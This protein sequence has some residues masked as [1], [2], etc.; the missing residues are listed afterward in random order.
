V[1]TTA[2]LPDLTGRRVIVTGANSGIGYQAALALAGAGA[3]VTMATRS[4]R[5]GRDAAA[6][7]QQALPGPARPVR[8][9][10]L[11]LAD[12]SSVREFA[13]AWDGPL[14]V[15]INNAGVMAI[16]KASSA[17]GFELQFGTNH[18][19]HFALTGLLLD[20]LLATPQARVVTL[21]SAV[22]YLGRIRFDDLDGDRRYQP[23]LAYGQSKLANLLFTAEL[24]RRVRAAGAGLLPVS[25]HPGYAHTNL[26]EASA[27][28]RG[29][30]LELALLQVVNRVIA[31]DPA[32]GALPTLYAATAPGVRSEVFYGPRTVYG[33]RGAP[34][35]TRAPKSAQD[36]EVAA[37]LWAVSE[38]RTGVTFAAL[39]AA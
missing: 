28:S 10:A 13:T 21:S 3:E 23:W 35:P 12:L 8:W 17:D 4:E 33:L 27:R 2:D 20:A 36:G 6:R 29:A 38:E 34:G 39:P 37:R 15:L 22:S 26:Q 30:R 16:P 1:W 11:D 14:H 19:G 32:A 7:L 5:R 31:Q 18:L 9:A 24:A 25:C